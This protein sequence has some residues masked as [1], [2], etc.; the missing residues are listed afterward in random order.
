ML[1]QRINRRQRLQFLS[2][3]PVIGEFLGMEARPRSDEPQRTRRERPIEY[4][5]RCELNLS[6]FIAVLG[7]EV[8]RRMIGTVHPY[9][10][11]IERSQA[12]HRAIV[13]YSAADVAAPHQRGRRLWRPW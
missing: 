11:S 4:S 13:S 10:D 1:G 6:D 12:R 8:R 5:Q 7:V 2:A 3:R 9:D